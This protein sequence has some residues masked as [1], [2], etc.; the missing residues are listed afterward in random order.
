MIYVQLNTQITSLVEAIHRLEIQEQSQFE[1]L[2]FP[3]ENDTTG[4]IEPIHT[5]SLITAGRLWERQQ[6]WET[7]AQICNAC[8]ALQGCLEPLGRFNLQAAE[9]GADE[10]F[11]DEVKSQ[12]IML[13]FMAAARSLDGMTFC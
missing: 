12:E 7:R 6:L 3:K 2:L 10:S 4:E 13:R 9:F 8:M 11:G 5:W 1:V